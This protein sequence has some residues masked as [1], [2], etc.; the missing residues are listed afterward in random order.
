ME[1]LSRPARPTTAWLLRVVPALDSL[2]SYGLAEARADAL[3]GLTVAAVAVPQAMAYAMIAGL[4]VEYGLYTAI[5]MTAVGAV[6]DSSRQLI[7]GPTNVISIAL[8]SV[9]GAVEGQD[10]KIQAAVLIACMVGTIQLGITLLRL[11]DLTRYISH[12]VIV[13][14][15][16]GASALLVLDQVKNLLGLRAVGGAAR[17]LPEALLA[18]LVGGGRGPAANRRRRT[19]HD[20]PRARAA[21]AEDESRLAAAARAADQRRGDGGPR[22]VAGPRPARRRRDRRDSREPAALP[23]AAPRRRA[24]QRSSRPAPS[25][26]RC[27]ASS[28]PSPWPRASPPRP[29][30]S[31]T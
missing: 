5:V 11:G 14:F 22:G 6:L 12:S 15:T 16:A 8:L 3:A 23:A 19:R 9:V 31:S 24:D 26:S 21:L 28:R 10:A 27:S 25:P 29:A 7:N 4:P 20:R 1:P 13:G 2:R 30:R 18:Q 17:P